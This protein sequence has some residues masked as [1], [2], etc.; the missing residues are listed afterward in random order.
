MHWNMA[1]TAV[2][3]EPAELAMPAEPSLPAEPAGG[4]AASRAR[5]RR[6]R[7]PGG[8][9]GGGAPMCARVYAAKTIA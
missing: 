1:S 4:C 6:G 8:Q 9:R 2:L 7:G 5:Q 3:A